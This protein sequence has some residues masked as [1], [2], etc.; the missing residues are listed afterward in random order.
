MQVKTDASGEIVYQKKHYAAGRHSIEL[1]YV[2]PD[3]KTMYLTDDGDGTMFSV[4]VASKAGD[5]D[6]GTIYGAK[7]TQ[8]EGGMNGAL[9]GNSAWH[10]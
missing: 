8:K 5:L 2:M 10:S 3:W 1:P 6:C 9:P 4:Y 7:M